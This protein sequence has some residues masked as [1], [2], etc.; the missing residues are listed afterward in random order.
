MPTIEDNIKAMANLVMT[1]KKDT[2][3]TENTILRIVD[4]NFALAQGAGLASMGGSE[5]IPEMGSDEVDLNSGIREQVIAFPQPDED[6]VLATTD[7]KEL[8][9]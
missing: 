2:H 8:E 4:M 5:E 7:H 6:E 1:V 3:L 9:N